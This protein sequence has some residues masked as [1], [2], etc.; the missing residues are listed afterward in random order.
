MEAVELQKRLEPGQARECSDNWQSIDE[1]RRPR[2]NPGE[3]GVDG[4][5]SSAA[6]L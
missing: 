6:F 5:E 2:D 1:S 3:A 4:R